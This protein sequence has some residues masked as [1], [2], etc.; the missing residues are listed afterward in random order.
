[1]H[2]IHTE[3]V[4]KEALAAVSFDLAICATGF[5]KRATH[6]IQSGVLTQVKQRCAIGFYDR[7]DSQRK[8]NDVAFKAANFELIDASGD[9]GRDIRLIVDRAVAELRSD[10]LRLVVDY[11]S[12]TR[13]WIG[14]VVEA[15]HSTKV[16]SC[17]CYFSYSPSVFSIPGEVRP[18]AA[19]GPVQGFSSLES[20][21]KPTALVLGLGYERERALGLM[22]YVDPALTFAFYTDPAFDPAFTK[23]VLKNNLGLLEGLPPENRIRHALG[24]LQQ[25]GNLLGSVCAGLRE[26][27]RIILAPMGVKPFALQCLLLASRFPELDVWRVSSGSMSDVQARPPYGPILVLK[28]VFAG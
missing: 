1:M 17:E 21:E 27:Y 25:T 22:E 7:I 4:E 14:A 9:S 5:E 26:E 13:P 3:Q 11:S 19:V 24:D 16:G 8:E 12:M 28:T 18:N 23:A 10:T 2:L 15:I 6:L 20:P